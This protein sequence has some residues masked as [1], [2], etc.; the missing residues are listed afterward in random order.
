MEGS[1]KKGRKGHNEMQTMTKIMYTELEIE[2][3]K[4]KVEVLDEKIQ[5]AEKKDKEL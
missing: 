2:K 1:D 3:M 4:D 5:Q